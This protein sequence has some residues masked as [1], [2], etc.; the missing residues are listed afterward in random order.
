MPNYQTSKPYQHAKP[1]QGWADTRQIVQTN[2]ATNLISQD[3]RRLKITLGPSGQNMLA[4][5]ITPLEI[6][7]T[8]PVSPAT[9]GTFTVRAAFW[10]RVT[11][12]VVAADDWSTQKFEIDASYTFTEPASGTVVAGFGFSQG[13]GFDDTGNYRNAR[14]VWWPFDGSPVGADSATIALERASGYTDIDVG[15]VYMTAGG[16]YN[17]IEADRERE[18]LEVVHGVPPGVALWV[19]ESLVVRFVTGSTT[20]AISDSVTLPDDGSHVVYLAGTYGQ[21][22]I[23]GDLVLSTAG[24]D[25]TYILARATTVGGVLTAFANTAN[26]VR[27]P[28]VGITTDYVIAQ[29]DTLHIKN[30]VIYSIT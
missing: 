27:F 17:F 10:Y 21:T 16:A 7:Y 23:Q 29:N 8:A 5:D 19:D 9:L 2:R 6:T 11:A 1:R 15:F 3:T 30:G 22:P 28:T 20:E 25:W 4:K 13:Q 24:K 26:A 12:P 18:W 14:L